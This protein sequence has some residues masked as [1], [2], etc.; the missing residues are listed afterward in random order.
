MNT[1][2]PWEQ[3]DWRKFLLWIPP[4]N[5]PPNDNN[6]RRAVRYAENIAVDVCRRISAR[7]RIEDLTRWAVR[8]VETLAVQVRLK[9]SLLTPSAA[10]AFVFLN[11]MLACGMLACG[12]LA[13]GIPISPRR[14]LPINL[15]GH[16]AQGVNLSGY[17]DSDPVF[18]LPLLNYLFSSLLGC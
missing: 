15:N 14:L 9:I 10:G 4:Q 1:T 2:A 3:S 18:F 16:G 12:M 11:P 8:H 7:W 5:F 17:Y 6:L 13:C